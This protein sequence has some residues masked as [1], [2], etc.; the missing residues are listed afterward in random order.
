[1]KL[2]R[3]Q[4][5]EYMELDISSTSMPTGRGAEEIIFSQSYFTFISSTPQT[6]K[7]KSLKC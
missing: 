4:K 1:M 2:L 6:Q 7:I 5:S 3:S